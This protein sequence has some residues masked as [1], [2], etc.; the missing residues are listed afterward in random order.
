M[1]GTQ[2]TPSSRVRG[3]K[4]SRRWAEKRFAKVAYFNELTKGGHFAAFEQP[5]TFIHE[6]RN[7]FRLIR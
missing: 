2:A 6:V 5:E 1:I 3:H 4:T 7:C